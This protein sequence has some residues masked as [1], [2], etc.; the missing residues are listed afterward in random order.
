MTGD[1]KCRCV[2]IVKT[3]NRYVTENTRGLV[4]G[5]LGMSDLAFCIVKQKA[6]LTAC[7]V[8]LAQTIRMASS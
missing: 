4:D 8:R 3:S 6:A 5:G 7:S 1:W 2:E